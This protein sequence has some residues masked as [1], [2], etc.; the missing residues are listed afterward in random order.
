MTSNRASAEAEQVYLFVQHLGRRLALL[1]SELGV[2]VARFSALAALM[3]HGVTNLT[4]LAAAEGVRAPSMTRLV[5]DMARD[6]LVTRRP[7]PED[8]RGVLIAITR[9]GRALVTR[10]RDRKIAL[11]AAYLRTLDAPARGH[12][13]AAFAAL[14]RLAEPDEEDNP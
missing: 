9:R 3:F 13:R 8:R 5:R 4:D 1:D 7:D 10:A 11:V 14:D 12:V 2:S 6:G